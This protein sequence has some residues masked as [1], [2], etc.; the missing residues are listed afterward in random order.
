MLKHINFFNH[1]VAGNEDA[2]QLDKAHLGYFFL[3]HYC[4]HLF[5]LSLTFS[6]T[7]KGCIV[8][9]A[10]IFLVLGIQ[11][12]VLW[13][14]SPEKGN[15]H[16]CTKLKKEY[17]LECIELNQVV[18]AQQQPHTEPKKVKE[19]EESLFLNSPPHIVDTPYH[20]ADT[21]FTE[22]LLF[23]PSASPTSLDSPS[24]SSK[25]PTGLPAYN[26]EHDDDLEP[27]LWQLENNL[28]IVNLHPSIWNMALAKYTQ[29][30]KIAFH[31]VQNNIVIPCLSWHKARDLFTTH[32]GSTELQTCLH[33]EFFKLSH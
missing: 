24:F 6:N 33:N 14:L 7:N 20:A 31:W 2:Y 10:K 4:S 25:I 30:S 8:T 27:F 23:S 5:Q 29:G 11:L 16:I 21:P 22:H 15:A 1:M 12:H 32:L 28:Q 17:R 26:P 9:Q 18:I 13:K 19:G 3:C